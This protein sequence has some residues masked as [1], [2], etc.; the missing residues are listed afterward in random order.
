MTI[1]V[2]QLI[3]NVYTKRYKSYKE[4]LMLIMLHNKYV[5][6]KEFGEQPVWQLLILS[7]PV[8]FLP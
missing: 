7:N 2:F 5:I 4:G 1:Q 6:N 8:S 3:T